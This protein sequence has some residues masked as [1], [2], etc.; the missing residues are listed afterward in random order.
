MEVDCTS[1]TGESWERGGQLA[2]NAF[3]SLQLTT[4]IF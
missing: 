1:L 2:K 3:P 4:G